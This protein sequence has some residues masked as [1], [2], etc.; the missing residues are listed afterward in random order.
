VRIACHAATATSR[1]PR[2]DRPQRRG[3]QPIG[4][5]R[6]GRYVRGVAPAEGFRLADAI[7]DFYGD[8]RLEPVLRSLLRHT[9]RLT[10]SAAGSVSLIDAAAGRYTKAAEYGA[11]CRLGDNV[12]AGRGATGRG[13]RQPPPG[14]HPRVRAVCGPGHLAGADPARHGPAAAV[15][16]WWRGE[17][18]AV[19]VT[20]APGAGAFSARDVDDLETLT[21]TAAAAIVRTSGPGTSPGH[22]A[23]PR[24][25]RGDR[26]RRR[27]PGRARGG[28][29]G[30][31]PGGR[32]RTE[33]AG[34]DRLPPRG[35]PG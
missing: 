16:I 12:P 7:A 5:C 29:G 21:Q 2:P 25:W 10:G 14:G 18:I 35:R 27:A 3:I 1:R 32:G 11:F 24:G 20:F 28:P 17:V 19:S 26:G 9:A 31:E 8:L 34:R 30:R 6:P 22:R 4:G 13:V 15:P 23:A 33:P